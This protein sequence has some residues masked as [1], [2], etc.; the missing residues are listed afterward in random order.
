MD[1]RHA[2]RAHLTDISASVGLSPRKLTSAATWVSAGVAAAAAIAAV[3][4]HPL[5]WTIAGGASLAAIAAASMRAVLGRAPS[6][7]LNT[8]PDRITDAQVLAVIDSRSGKITASRLADMTRSTADAA[9]VKL[10]SMAIDG[11]LT[12]DSESS[13]VELVYVSTDRSLP[14]PNA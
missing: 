1:L 7:K 2:I 5:L 11:R 6:R 3:A 10:R 4:L 12:V 8:R 13:E 9:E 14:D